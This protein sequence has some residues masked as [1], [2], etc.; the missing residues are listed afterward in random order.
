MSPTLQQLFQ[1]INYLFQF[2]LTKIIFLGDTLL[3][4]IIIHSHWHLMLLYIMLKAI[5]KRIFLFRYGAFFRKVTICHPRP[6]R[7]NIQFVAKQISD[8]LKS[9]IENDVQIESFRM[10]N[11]MILTELNN[12]YTS[13]DHLTNFLQTQNNLSYIDFTDGRTNQCCGLNVLENIRPE[14]VTHLMLHIF[15]ESE[16]SGITRSVNSHFI[17]SPVCY[18][19]NFMPTSYLFR[20]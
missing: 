1:H 3:P 9:L 4:I 20:R 12:E 11:L 15:F 19:L 8:L 14:P 5:Y 16:M 17:F 18:N 6:Q 2:I 13:C 10:N 7:N